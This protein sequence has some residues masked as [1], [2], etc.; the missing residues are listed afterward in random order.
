M[1]AARE[2]MSGLGIPLDAVVFVKESYG[3]PDRRPVSLSRSV[4]T[5]EKLTQWWDT[6][7][8]GIQYE[9]KNQSGSGQLCTLGP[10]VLKN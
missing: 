5:A 1:E 9:Y 6:I 7:V 10:M 8:G 2:Q 4:Q 3:V